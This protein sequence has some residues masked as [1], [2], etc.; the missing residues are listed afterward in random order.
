MR[1]AK[2]EQITS[3]INTNTIDKEN[4]IDDFHKFFITPLLY[5]LDQFYHFFC[6]KFGL[7][8]KLFN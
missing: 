5:N 2:I 7:N 8:K 6:I 4:R 1:R 3:L